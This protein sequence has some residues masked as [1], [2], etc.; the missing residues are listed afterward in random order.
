M[1]WCWKL[2]RPPFL[3]Q[4]VFFVCF[5]F[6]GESFY[7]FPSDDIYAVGFVYYADNLLFYRHQNSTPDLA[8]NCGK[9]EMIARTSDR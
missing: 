4:D 2:R 9:Y 8:S 3:M 5:R 1:R 7:L 6:Y